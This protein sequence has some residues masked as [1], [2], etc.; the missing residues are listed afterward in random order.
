MKVEDGIFRYLKNL[1]SRT[2]PPHASFHPLYSS[3]HNNFRGRLKPEPNRN[4]FP[5]F[6]EDF[7]VPEISMSGGK[8]VH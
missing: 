4:I 1:D 3:D 2:F 5:V 6:K 8:F 7:Q